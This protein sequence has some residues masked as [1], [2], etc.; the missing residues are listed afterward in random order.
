MSVLYRYEFPAS[1]ANTFQTQK[2]RTLKD[3][4]GTLQYGNG[5]ISRPSKKNIFFGR[6]GHFIVLLLN[7]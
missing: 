4:K 7:R 1:L 5:T 6:N 3:V 2:L